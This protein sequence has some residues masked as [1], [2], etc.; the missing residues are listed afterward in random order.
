MESSRAA[1]TARRN[2]G[3]L[4]AGGT[5]VPRNSHRVTFVA[6]AIGTIGRLPVAS[7]CLWNSRGAFAANGWWDSLPG[8]RS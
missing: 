3:I 1:L 6:L 7:E 4:L 2:P 8:Q 5:R